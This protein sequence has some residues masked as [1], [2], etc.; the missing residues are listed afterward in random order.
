MLRKFNRF[1]MLPFAAITLFALAAWAYDAIVDHA[2][3]QVNNNYHF[4]Y[5]V[6]DGNYTSCTYAR[7]YDSYVPQPSM[8]SYWNI[9]L[10]NG[11]GGWDW[12]DNPLYWN[13][14]AKTTNGYNRLYTINFPQ[15]LGN[16]ACPDER[17]GL[18]Y[19]QPCTAD[20]NGNR[21]CVAKWETIPLSH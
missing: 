18:F 6:Y 7:D 4:L 14:A 11:H 10:N 8:I 3:A 19:A 16:R 13:T 15:F 1:V 12:K 9:Y 17:P 5:R 21:D 20:A 2:T